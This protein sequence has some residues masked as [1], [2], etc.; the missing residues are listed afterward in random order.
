MTAEYVSVG[1]IDEFPEGVI[2]SFQLES[3]NVA[4]VSW[5]ENYYAFDNHCTHLGYS[6]D[7]GGFV[8]PDN[9]LICTSHFSAYDLETGRQTDGPGFGGLQV[10]DVRIE[11]GELLVSKAP[12]T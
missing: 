3:A 10:F 12:R 1:K 9:E 6:F 5:R 2:R 8:S 7:P 4:V 11:D